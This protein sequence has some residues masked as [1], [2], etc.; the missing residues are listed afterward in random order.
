MKSFF[1]K[2]AVNIRPAFQII[3]LI[4]VGFLP[5]L[6]NVSETVT[7]Q[8]QIT[9]SQKWFDYVFYFVWAMGD[10][11]IGLLFLIIAL[12]S[13]RKINKGYIFNKGDVYKN[14]PY[15][16]YWV[17]AKILGYS[18][19]NLILVP[20]FMQFKLVIQDTFDKYHC[21]N[22]NK[23]DN[24]IISVNKKNMSSTSDEAN[25]IIADTYP[26]DVKQ[27]PAA[28]RANLTILILRD[29]SV[30]HNRYDSPNLVQAVVN[31][32]RNLPFSIKK[33]NVFATTNPQNTMNI[34]SN[35]FKLGERS[36][37]DEVTVFQQKRT[38]NPRKFQKKGKVVYKR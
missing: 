3:G 32:V 1:K 33:V 37:L 18:E 10:K 28:K 9:V 2:L 8:P 34:A 25:L 29:N 36:N 13:V 19:C 23:K 20:I 30:D 17:C 12:F 38:G 16:W 4:L 5:S 22:L 27:I 31:E 24:D 7:E 21:G 26:L 15:I 14:Y 35:A 6:L 11:A